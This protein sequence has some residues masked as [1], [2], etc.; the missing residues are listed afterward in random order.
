MCH[1]RHPIDMD[2][3][4]LR[5]GNWMFLTSSMSGKRSVWSVNHWHL[6]EGNGKICVDNLHVMK[7]FDWII[8]LTSQGKKTEW[9]WSL[10]CQV[11]DLIDRWSLTSQ[12]RERK[13]LWITGMPWMA[14]DHWHLRN[15]MILI[16]SIAGKLI[17]D[18]WHLVHWYLKDENWMI[19]VLTSLRSRYLSCHV[20][21]KGI[22]WSPKYLAEK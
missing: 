5:E 16:F 4:H 18:H 9:S 19:W 22:W 12:G 10:A 8:S 2:H 14:L 13:D 20:L 1:A 15:W 11:R 7:G 6:R 21:R 17:G 3:W